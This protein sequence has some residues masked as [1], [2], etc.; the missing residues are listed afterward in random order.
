MAFIV[1]KDLKLVVP[2]A[3]KSS[4]VSCV[5]LSHFQ[6]TGSEVNNFN[7]HL[8]VTFRDDCRRMEEKQE[9]F[10]LDCFWSAQLSV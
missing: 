5:F 2:E 4:P 1:E 10:S 3:L 6:S 8:A 7:I 9:K